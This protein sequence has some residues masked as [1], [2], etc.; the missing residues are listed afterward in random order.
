MELGSVGLKIAELGELA[1]WF[2]GHFTGWAGGYGGREVISEEMHGY[3]GNL[4]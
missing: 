3:T 4:G 2:R 1:G